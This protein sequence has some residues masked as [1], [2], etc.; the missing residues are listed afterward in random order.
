MKHFKALVTIILTAAPLF[1]AADDSPLPP[2]PPER[3]PVAVTAE[4]VTL[5]MKDGSSLRARIVDQSDERLRIVTA[6][7][8][9]MEIARASV[10]RVETEGDG[11]E[12]P[13]PSDSNC[14]RLLFS[15]TGR[16]LAR[17]EGYFSDHYVVFPGVTYGITD[18][19]SIGAGTSVIPGLGLSEQLLYVSPRF[20]KQF[21]DKVAVSAGILYAREGDA[22]PEGQLGM[23]FAMATFGRPERS[24]TL[25]A[26]VARTVHEEYYTE[27][28]N[29]EW[30][31]DFRYEAAY[32]P[33]V[34]VGGTARLSPRIALVSE[35]W[36][37]LG[38]GFKLS[39]QPFAVGVRFLGDR[40]T[41]D[42]GMV[43]VGEVIE[44][45][46]P[47]PW[48]SVTYHFGGRKQGS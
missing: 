15:P 32:T 33:T 13:R 9:A 28:V 5:R 48:L 2:S 38:E 14:T 42:V 20:G 7:G 30:R 17:G 36:L 22:G 35:N 39:E 6:E 11:E 8:V 37:I 21:T 1:A 25:G 34:M 18:N 44:E 47:I 3:A 10:D 41:A 31:G 19:L 43:L 4:F 26:G 23:G 27:E 46:Y 16:P 24:L 12:A 45:G 40:L 29:G